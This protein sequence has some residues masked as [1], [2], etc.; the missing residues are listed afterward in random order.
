MEITELVPQ[1]LHA[2]LYAFFLNVCAAKEKGLLFL[3][4]YSHRN[5]VKII[6]RPQLL[7]ITEKACYGYTVKAVF[8]SEMMTHS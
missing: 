2:S 8:V 7:I 5:E 6:F 3:S 1:P 4:Y